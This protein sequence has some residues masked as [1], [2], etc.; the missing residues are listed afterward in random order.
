VL[1]KSGVWDKFET[2]WVCLDCELMPGSAKAR[3]LLKSQYA[4][5]GA[6]AAAALA[7]TISILTQAANRREL[8]KDFTVP[9]NSSARPT[10][11]DEVWKWCKNRLK[12][13]KNY[14]LTDNP[15]FHHAN[16]G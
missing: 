14:R 5:V 10:D 2:N 16:Q 1:L 3:D 6:A 13:V 7:E 8:E 15:L 4:A 9:P 11:I 12:M